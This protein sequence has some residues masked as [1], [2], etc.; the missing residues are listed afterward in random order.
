MKAILPLLLVAAASMGYF[1]LSQPYMEVKLSNAADVE[2]FSFVGQYN[3]NY[4]SAQEIKI[5]FE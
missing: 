4:K 2:F 5:R 3:K 1:Y